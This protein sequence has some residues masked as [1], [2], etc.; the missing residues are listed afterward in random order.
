MQPLATVMTYLKPSTTARKVRGDEE[1]ER[2]GC[3]SAYPLPIILRMTWVHDDAQQNGCRWTC[4]GK[5]TLQRA[6][7]QLMPTR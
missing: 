3:E 1:V 4:G 5:R 6:G 2:I 7:K